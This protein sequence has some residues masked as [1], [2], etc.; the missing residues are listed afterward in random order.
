MNK[1]KKDYN[2]IIASLEEELVRKQKQIDNLKE[3]NIILLK[4]ALKNQKDK[5]KK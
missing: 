4:T 1:V 2:K 3:Q 5:L